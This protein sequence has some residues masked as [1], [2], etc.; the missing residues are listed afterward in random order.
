MVLTRTRPGARAKPGSTTATSSNPPAHCDLRATPST[1]SPNSMLVFGDNTLNS[2][3]SRY[4]GL[5][6]EQ[7]VIGK[8]C[9]VYWPISS[10]FGWGQR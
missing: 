9:F 5:F 1:S 7:N 3:D 2:L 6:P 4:W 10:R 8:S